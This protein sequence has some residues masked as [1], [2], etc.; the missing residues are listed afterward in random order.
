MTAQHL[1]HE[2]HELVHDWNRSFLDTIL[3]APGD[4]PSPGCPTKLDHG[5]GERWMSKLALHWGP[6]LC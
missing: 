5:R 6:S 2:G 1:G 3:H 4:A